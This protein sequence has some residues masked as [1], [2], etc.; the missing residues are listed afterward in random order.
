VAGWG[1][2]MV[3]DRRLS[4]CEVPSC[5]LVCIVCRGMGIHRGSRACLQILYPWVLLITPLTGCV[6]NTCVCY[7]VD[8][9]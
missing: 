8:H 9:M 4:E 7:Q 1:G 6:A 2:L 3:L 5:Y